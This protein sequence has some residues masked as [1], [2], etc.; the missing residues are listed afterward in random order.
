MLKYLMVALFSVHG[1]TWEPR[2]GKSNG[3]HTCTRIR[4]SLHFGKSS[5]ERRASRDGCLLARGKL[6]FYWADLPACE[7]SLARAVEDRSH[8]A[9]LAGPLGH[10]PWSE[11]HLCA[12]EPDNQK[13]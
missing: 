9:A 10:D 11:L 7:S 5:F 13:I 2:K 8:Q 12:Y 3:R 6:S 4:Q 1:A